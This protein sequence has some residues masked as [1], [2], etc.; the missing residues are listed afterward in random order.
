MASKEEI[1]QKAK[2]AIESFN[3]DEAVAAAKEALDAN[4]DPVEVITVLTEGM[5][6]VG[7]KFDKGEYFL[8]HV[9][10]ASEAMKVA[11]AVVEPALKAGAKAGDKLGTVVIGTVEGDIHSIGKDIVAT[12]LGIAGFEVHDLGRDV[13]VTE[14]AAKAKEV[15]ADIVGSSALMTTTMLNQE[16]VE[17]ELKKAGIRDKV[18]TMVG[19]APITQ[20]WA[21][22]V[23]ADAYAE[24]ATEAVVVAKKLMAS[25]KEV[26]GA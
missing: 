3:K 5:R 18:K 23:G 17:E 10:A 9:M 26:K 6:E 15:N 1:L 11:V 12:M 20:E 4:I 2:N 22:K 14:F 25:L 8:P 21:D 24:S 19:G 16:R 7:D 13:P